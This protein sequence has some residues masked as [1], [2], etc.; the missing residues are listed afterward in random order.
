MDPVSSYLLDL[1]TVAYCAIIDLSHPLSAEHT[2]VS[3]RDNYLNPKHV[4][5]YDRNFCQFGRP[6]VLQN[7]KFIAAIMNKYTVADGDFWEKRVSPS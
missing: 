2:S 7:Y 3:P 5:D 1:H 6:Y 4:D